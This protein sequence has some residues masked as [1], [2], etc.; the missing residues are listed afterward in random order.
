MK[1]L[2]LLDQ[3]NMTYLQE[4]PLEDIIMRFSTNKWNDHL[5]LMW[6]L[7]LSIMIEDYTLPYTWEMYQNMNYMCLP[8]KYRP[9]HLLILSRSR[10]HPNMVMSYDAFKSL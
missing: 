10:G 1:I 6:L 2:D 5:D 4:L 9:S 3:T 7:H 8:L